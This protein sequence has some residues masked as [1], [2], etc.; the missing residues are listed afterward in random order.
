MKHLRKVAHL[1]RMMSYLLGNRPYESGLVPD[2]EGYITI[3]E[4]LNA[5]HEEPSMGYVRESH[6]REVLIHDSDGIFEID[7]KSIRSTRPNFSPV[8]RGQ[9][10][11]PPKILFTGV[12]R[13]V[14][15]HI[16]KSGLF[17]GAKDYVVLSEDS[18]LALRI[19]KLSD[20][21]PVI[22]EI[23]AGD[24]HLKRIPFYH[25]GG[26]LYLTTTVPVEFISGPP[27]PKEVPPK[28]EPIESKRETVPGSFFL[29]VERDPDLKRRRDVSKK[30]TWKEESN[31]RTKRKKA[32][33]EEG[34]LQDSF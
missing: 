27:L 31:K 19:A 10:H 32:R 7:G 2:K 24:A 16:M 33:R 11:A 6:V 34:R 29:K 17:P 5:I 22:L 28:K 14:Y 12:K 18:E 25:F 23:W 15:P 4:F 13:K 3:K 8:K 20:Q 21:S 30:R 1:G 26:S 9:K